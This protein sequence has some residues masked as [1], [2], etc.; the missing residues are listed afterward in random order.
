MKSGRGGVRGRPVGR[1]GGGGEVGREQG[2]E[3][4]GGGKLGRGAQW[5]FEVRV[6][7]I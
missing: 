7:P 1:V 2:W 6:A 4:G 3:G 5:L